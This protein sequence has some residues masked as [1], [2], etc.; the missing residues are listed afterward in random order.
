MAESDPSVGSKKRVLSESMLSPQ[1][2][3]SVYA[4]F[5]DGH[6]VQDNQVT[7]KHHSVSSSQGSQGL[8][9]SVGLL[10]LTIDSSPNPKS[11]SSPKFALL[12][13]KVSD[14]EMEETNLDVENWS[15]FREPATP[16]IPKNQ[17][18]RPASNSSTSLSP[19]ISDSQKP[20]L[21]SSSKNNTSLEGNRTSI[22]MKLNKLRKMV[23][24][25]KV[26]TDSDGI[27]PLP[28]P[29]MHFQNNKENILDSPTNSP[30]RPARQKLKL[31]KA[32]NKNLSGLKSSQNDKEG[33][34]VTPNSYKFVK[35]LQTAF[36]SSGLLSK[37]NRTPSESFHPP[38]TPCKKPIQSNLPASQKQTF[39]SSNLAN[40]ITA[41]SPMINDNSTPK[42]RDDESIHDSAYEHSPSHNTE[43]LPR[44]ARA[45]NTSGLRDCIWKFSND[46]DD[47]IESIFEENSHDEHDPATPTRLR[48]AKRVLMKNLRLNTYEFNHG[49]GSSAPRTPNDIYI[50]TTADVSN[51]SSVAGNTSAFSTTSSVDD[52]L[53]SKFDNVQLVGQGEFSNVFEITF[54]SVKYAVKR[55]KTPFLGLKRRKRIFEEVELLKTLQENEPK[56][57]EG[58]EYVINFINDWEQNDHL[59]IMMELCE[60]GPLDRFLADSGKLSKIDEWR[61]WK[62]MV[63]IAM[64]LKYIHSCNIMHLDLKPANI[65]IT[66][67]GSLKIGD[68][69]MAAK[70]PV[71][72]GFEREGDREYIAP[73]II[74]QS[75]YDKPADIFSFGLIMVEIAANIVLPE[76]GIQ[77]HKLRSGDLS[78]AG[79]LS[80]GDLN[81]NLFND[82]MNSRTS[83]YSSPLNITAITGSSYSSVG[84]NYKK[85]PS[86]TPKFLV[87]GKCALDK[88]VQK[89]INP[90]PHQRPTA[91][92]ICNTLE[93][94]FVE[95]RRKAGAV[96]YEGEYGPQPDID[97][98]S[99]MS[100]EVRCL[101]LGAVP[102]VTTIPS[103][104]MDQDEW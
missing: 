97:E 46:F 68:F 83:T 1:L 89:M 58:K 18:K 96:I 48:D 15:P 34:F 16:T 42:H 91:A 86:W 6:A 103:D 27:H 25:D 14:Q 40:V 24:L 104:I 78:E 98:E 82:S 72:G 93:A 94:Q 20:L 51:I 35:P 59:Y 28:S 77:W 70:Y 102:L 4:S 90:A 73:E 71:T 76:N 57:D 21:F 81:M 38:E 43:N 54:Q 19:F 63:E 31:D 101:N 49:D 88:V 74:H 62:I 36:M 87:D 69:G 53:T 41:S 61:I 100:N 11:F 39:P 29:S 32:T 9:R 64:G 75:K 12:K 95:V 99:L 22:Q 84:E 50:D 65:F 47:S 37:K 10:N 13:K 23:S 45:L 7:P 5:D 80:S 8:R 60:N 17:L 92:D 79:R 66:F 52:H 33:D 30:S 44:S 56:D 26:N 67:E 3:N 55:I 2:K 85:L